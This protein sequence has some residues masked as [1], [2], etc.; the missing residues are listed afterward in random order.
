MRE[1]KVRGYAVEKLIGRQWVYGTGIH[2]TVFT[3]EYAKQTGIK[4]ECFVWTSTGWTEVQKESIRQYT[5]LKDKNGSEIYEGDIVRYTRIVYADCSRTEIEDIEESVIGE[6]Y[7][8]EGLWIGFRFID[9][10]GKL[11]LPGQVSSED[12]NPEIEVIG[13]LYENPELL[14]VSK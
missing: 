11:F 13:N 4:E 5:G 2:I 7:Y 6:V 10:T 3:D 8:A 14:E 12:N 1:I 9:G